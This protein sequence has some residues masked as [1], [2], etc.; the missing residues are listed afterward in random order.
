VDVLW[1]DD[2]PAIGILASINFEIEGVS[3]ATA[4][5]GR[6]GLDAAVELEP[7]VVFL[8]WMMPG[9]DGGTALIALRAD[10]RTAHIP[11][12][13]CT[14]K[15]LATDVVWALQRGASGYLPKPFAPS[16]LADIHAEVTGGPARPIACYFRPADVPGLLADA[17]DQARDAGNDATAAIAAALSRNSLWAARGMAS[18]VCEYASTPDD[19]ADI[20]DTPAPT[21]LHDARRG[22]LDLIDSDE[23]LASLSAPGRRLVDAVGD[24]HRA[25]QPLART[26]WAEACD[27]LSEELQAVQNRAPAT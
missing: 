26:A 11:V 23:G 19:H 10:R 13:M 4:V 16:S 17:A 24:E 6:S 22:L 3:T 21:R 7:S 27:S 15:S 8:D 5:D 18:L 12:V 2:E 14:A 20:G 9:I 25:D 1:I